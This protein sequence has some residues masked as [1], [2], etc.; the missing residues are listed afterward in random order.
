MVEPYLYEWTGK[1]IFDKT[2]DK[3]FYFNSGSTST[4]TSV[5]SGGYAYDNPDFPIYRTDV[6]SSMNTGDNFTIFFSFMTLP[7][8]VPV[9][10]GDFV[11]FN[12]PAL[13][14]NN[15]GFRID[16][17][18]I[19]FRGPAQGDYASQGLITMGS[20][21]KSDYTYIS[22]NNN[23]F[24]LADN[25]YD[26]FQ[27]TGADFLADTLVIMYYGNFSTSTTYSTWDFGFRDNVQLY[28]G[29]ASNFP[30]L[31]LDEYVPG[32]ESIDYNQKLEE[33]IAGVSA[34]GKAQAEAIL[35]DFNNVIGNETS[36][37][38]GVSAATNIMNVCLGIP[39]LGDIIQFALALGMF[40]F[41]VGMGFLYNSARNRSSKSEKYENRG[42]G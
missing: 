8:T 29:D 28:S 4:S 9:K 19:Y 20:Y 1:E 25:F 17:I 36:I 18:Y 33:Q 39:F 6:P 2:R 10:N 31:N 21:F 34:D 42:D 16:N 32:Q 3:R 40:S 37:F 14:A 12:V 35:K 22:S 27:W 38:R 15:E 41:V 30:V 5:R 26:S 23:Y 13:M 11:S 7:N 24:Q